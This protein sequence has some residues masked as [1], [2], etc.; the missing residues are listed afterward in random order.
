MNKEMLLCTGLLI[1][2]ADY[3]GY[4]LDRIMTDVDYL[5]GTVRD[6][7]EFGYDYEEI[8][9]DKIIKHLE[10]YSRILARAVS[11]I[12]IMENEGE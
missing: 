8:P 1:E 9:Y 11:E 12:S 7:K 6:I 3:N 2:G 10:N 5:V 4:Y